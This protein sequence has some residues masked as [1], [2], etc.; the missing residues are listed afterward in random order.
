MTEIGLSQAPA[1]V[2]AVQGSPSVDEVVGRATAAARPFAEL[3]LA[4]R[5]DVLTT[6][7]GALEAHAEELVALAAQETGL[8]PARLHGELTRTAVQLR[9][10]AGVVVDGSFAEQ[11]LD[12]ADPDF[13]LGPRPEL[14]RVLLP[15]GPVA[16]FAASNFPFAFSVLGGDTASALAAGCPVVVKA[17]PGHPR[18]SER[19][20][21]IAQKALT[22]TG[23]PAGVL[24]LIAGESE[25]VELLRHP[26]V[27]AASFT[28]SFRGGVFLAGIAAARPR[29]IP[30]FGELGSVNPVFVTPDAARDEKIAT[31]YAASVA[32]SAGQLCTKPGFLFA[33]RGSAVAERAAAALDA[34]APHRMLYPALGEGYRRRRSEI[35]SA[36]GVRVLQEGTAGIDDDG[37]T[38]V[39]PTLVAVTPEALEAAREHLLDEAFGPLSIVVEY[40]GPDSLPGLLTRLFEGSLTATLWS[41][42]ADD[43]QPE[44]WLHELRHGLADLG[45]RVLQNGWPTGVAVSPAQQHGGPWPSSTDARSTSVGT[46]AIARFLRPVTFQS[47]AAAALP[48]VARSAAGM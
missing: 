10:L 25:G 44:P 37:H 21:A 12:A 22:V 41:T 48:A 1:P 6:L 7:A 20:A 47:V 31:G 40:E 2:D 26:D 33:P 19:T 8:A 13:A 17:H 15:I 5:A 32:G 35:L 46:A 11:R 29:P 39:T 16:V 45:G 9:L 14:R 3:S 18:L 38:W 24:G 43:A 4:R 28:G 34:V 36:P 27:R 23:A 30:F 42:E